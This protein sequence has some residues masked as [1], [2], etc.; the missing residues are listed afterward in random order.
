MFSHEVRQLYHYYPVKI[1]FSFES[2]FYQIS[3]FFFAWGGARLVP[4]ASPPCAV[5]DNICFNQD[6]SRGHK[7]TKQDKVTLASFRQGCFRKQK[8]DNYLST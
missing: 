2:V 8:R 6:M 3:F 4:L 1:L 7:E 5:R